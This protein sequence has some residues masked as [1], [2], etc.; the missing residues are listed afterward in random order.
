[1]VETELKKIF[2]DL[3]DVYEDDNEENIAKRETD[4]FQN[5][6]KSGQR[7]Q[8]HGWIRLDKAG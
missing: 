8:K 5:N 2:K 3:K 4:E 6:K 1:M 7:R